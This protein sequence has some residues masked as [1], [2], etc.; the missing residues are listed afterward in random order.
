MRTVRNSTYYLQEYDK[1]YTRHAKTRMRRLAWGVQF[2]QA[3][4]TSVDL[5]NQLR[6]SRPHTHVR[7][8]FEHAQLTYVQ[9]LTLSWTGYVRHIESQPILS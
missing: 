8:I 2:A 1:I 6:S 7:R 3:N 9:R 4:F 5:K